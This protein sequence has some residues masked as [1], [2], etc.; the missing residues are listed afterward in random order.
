MRRTA[1]Y[2]L[3]P[4]ASKIQRPVHRR[5]LCSPCRVYRS[6]LRPLRAAPSDGPNCL[7]TIRESASST[8]DASAARSP[9]RVRRRCGECDAASVDAQCGG[10]ARLRAAGVSAAVSRHGCGSQEVPHLPGHGLLQTQQSDGGGWLQGTAQIRHTRQPASSTHSAATERGGV[11]G[12]HCA[13]TRQSCCAS[14]RA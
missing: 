11:N 2:H 10:G 8:F 9:C 13:N 4:A 14:A 7:T 1:T 3:T 6:R 12:D 5:L